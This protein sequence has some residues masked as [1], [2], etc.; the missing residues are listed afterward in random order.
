MGKIR[1]KNERLK[2]TDVAV[3]AVL[4]SGG[5]IRLIHLE[6]VA[7]K[8][9]ELVPQRF[10]W[11]K[12]PEQINL[13]LVRIALKNEMGSKENR[14]RG[15]IREGYMLTPNGLLWFLNMNRHATDQITIQSLYREV[16]QAKRTE[17]FLKIVNRDKVDISNQ[18]IDA[19]L[20]VDTYSTP[21]TRRERVTTLANAAVLD[22]QLD[23]VLNALR[24]RGFSE[25]EVNK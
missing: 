14:V 8:A 21:R 22:S 19:L 25:L 18:D 16:E 20:R 10:R 23:Q 1:G 5:A 3:L 12:Y 9:F 17:A 15:G 4:Y 2:N 6:D 24:K 11:E 7:V 13:E